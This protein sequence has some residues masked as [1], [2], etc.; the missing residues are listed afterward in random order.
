[1]M[2]GNGE[3]ETVAKTMLVLMVRGLCTSLQ[4]P[5]AQ[6]ACSAL[7][8]HQMYQPIMEAV[9]RLERIG[10]KVSPIYMQKC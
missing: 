10:L 7:K 2:K 4:Y 6:F 3:E 1:M 9:F 8:A 5:F